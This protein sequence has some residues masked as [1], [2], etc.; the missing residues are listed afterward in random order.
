MNLYKITTLTEMSDALDE[1]KFIDCIVSFERI[2]EIYSLVDIN[3]YL[4]SINMPRFRTTE[5]LREGGRELIYCFKSLSDYLRIT[6]D[7]ESPRE[8]GFP[9]FDW[10]VDIDHTNQLNLKRELKL[11]SILGE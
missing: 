8:I 3:I 4:D 7:G 11:T 1:S 10:I 9:Q 5:R 2:G 6:V